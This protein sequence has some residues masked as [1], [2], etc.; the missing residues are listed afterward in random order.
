MQKVYYEVDPYNRLVIDGT[1]TES[2]LRKFRKV[3]DGRFR[4]DENNVLSYHIKAPLAENEDIPHQVKISGDWSLTD[5]H[6]LRLTLDKEG[7]GTF[8]D[9]ITLQGRILDVDKNSLAFSTSP[10]SIKCNAFSK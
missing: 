4:V 6:E 2:E 7:R 10:A 5:G 9:Q 8:G 1:G 3:L